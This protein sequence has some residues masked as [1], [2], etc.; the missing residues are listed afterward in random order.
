[1]SVPISITCTDGLGNLLDDD[2]TT[3]LNG[4]DPDT[5][6]E[7]PLMAWKRK[8]TGKGT[9]SSEYSVKDVIIL[10]QVYIWAY[11]NAIDGVSH[12]R[13]KFWDDMFEAGSICLPSDEEAEV[14][15]HSA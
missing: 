4:E 9:K 7:E 12:K 6:N 15:L 5:K 13:P 8:V 3:T 10:S 2:D 11:E 14:S 1:M